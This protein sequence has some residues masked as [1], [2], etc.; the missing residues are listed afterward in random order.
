MGIRH[1]DRGIKI[2]HNDKI[3]GFTTSYSKVFR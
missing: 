2:N 3:F 1:T